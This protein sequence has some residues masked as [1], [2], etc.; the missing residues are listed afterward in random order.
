LLRESIHENLLLIHYYHDK[1]KNEQEQSALLD[2]IK[3]LQTHHGFMKSY[4]S[5][6]LPQI[7]LKRGID[8]GNEELLIDVYRRAKLFQQAQTQINDMRSKYPWMN[9]N[10]ETYLAHQERLIADKNSNLI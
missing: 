4:S 2:L 1:N 8:L 10:T 9:C 7:A 6:Q 3:I 5:K